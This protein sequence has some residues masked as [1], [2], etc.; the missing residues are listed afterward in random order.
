MQPKTKE[1]AVA[2]F[3]A[4][5]PHQFVM[6]AVSGLL[7]L[8]PCAAAAQDR[9]PSPADSN[10]GSADDGV[11]LDGVVTVLTEIQVG[12]SIRDSEAPVEEAPVDESTPELPVISDHTGPLSTPNA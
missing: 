5:S 6:L 8:A 1:V 9:D 11:D 3:N 2:I 12:T 7:V 4:P 10:T